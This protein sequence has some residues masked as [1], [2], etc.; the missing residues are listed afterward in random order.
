[1]GL[2]VR[3]KQ[4]ETDITQMMFYNKYRCF[5]FADVFDG[6]IF[7]FALLSLFWYVVLLL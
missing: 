7:Q 3:K 2:F 5:G 6:A 4:N 1:M